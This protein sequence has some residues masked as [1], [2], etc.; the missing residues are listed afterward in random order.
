MDKHLIVS[1]SLH[2]FFGNVI[3]KQ[4]D[5]FEQQHNLNHQYLLNEVDLYD[6]R[7]QEHML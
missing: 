6:N 7:Y 2:S 3:D 1:D 5:H 4:H